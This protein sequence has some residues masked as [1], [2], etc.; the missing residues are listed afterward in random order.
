MNEQERVKRLLE[1]G[2]ERKYH[3]HC[4]ALWEHATK[5]LGVPS[6]EIVSFTFRD[7]YLSE[8]RVAEIDAAAR[9]RAGLSGDFGLFRN[10]ERLAYSAK[11]HNAVRL[12]N[13]DI[14]PMPL[15][16]RPQIPANVKVS[17]DETD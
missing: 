9:N 10:T 3:L 15:F 7:A 2:E 4:I 6:E 5:H 12:T 8:A 11:Y 13:G 14:V 16:P 17:I 1:L